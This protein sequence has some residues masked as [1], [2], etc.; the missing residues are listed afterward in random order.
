[1]EPSRQGHDACRVVRSA[2][3]APAPR[4]PRTGREQSELAI[5]EI[6]RAAVQ[7]AGAIHLGPGDE[8]IQNL[9][10]EEGPHGRSVH[11]E[12]LDVLGPELVAMTLA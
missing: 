12:V 11:Q 6:R 1:M 3:P 9:P 10:P 2:P 4:S 5:H 7:E 8:P